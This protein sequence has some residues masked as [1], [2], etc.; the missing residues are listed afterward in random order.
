MLAELLNRR[1]VSARALCS[2]ALAGECVEA[3][4]QAKPKVVCVL[5]VPPYGYMHA[6]YLCRRLQTELPAIKVVAA[7]LTEGDSEELKK[8]EPS[9]PASEV[10]ASLKEA[11]NAIVALEPTQDTEPAE[12]ALSHR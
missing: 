8:R 7:V 12:P 3:V 2:T 6:R 5:S 4:T 10:V 1:G 11:L 9:L